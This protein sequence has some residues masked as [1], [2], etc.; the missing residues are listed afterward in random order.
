[1]RGI[2][3]ILVCLVVIVGMVVPA[4]AGH[5]DMHTQ[6]MHIEAVVAYP[7][8]I[9]EHR[10]LTTHTQPAS[11][12]ADVGGCEGG[13][14]AESAAPKC[15]AEVSH[16]LVAFTGPTHPGVPLKLSRQAGHGLHPGS[17]APHR[18][19]ETATPPPRV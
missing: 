9:T 17:A 5:P 3:T 19:P 11:E 10:D 14:C 15:L 13:N 6:K 7:D 18:T 2:G 4:V 12:T 1:M 8:E 16:C